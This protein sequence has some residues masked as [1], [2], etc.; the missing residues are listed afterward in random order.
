MRKVHSV[1]G[2]RFIVI[3]KYP[4]IFLHRM[5][6]LPTGILTV[7]DMVKLSSKSEL[8]SLILQNHNYDMRLMIH[9]PLPQPNWLARELLRAYR[10]LKRRTGISCQF[11]DFILSRYTAIDQTSREN[12][13]DQIQFIVKKR[14]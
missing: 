1:H 3:T 5:L 6:C 7:L 12:A 8:V 14:V 10:S 4:D 13:L 9:G 2:Y 11:L